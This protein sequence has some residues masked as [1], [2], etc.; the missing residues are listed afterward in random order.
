MKTAHIFTLVIAVGVIV[1][2]VV[3]LEAARPDDGAQFVSMWGKE[4]AGQGEFVGP[5]DIAVDQEGFVYVMD[6]YNFRIQKFTSEGRFLI[7]WGE[8]GK[9]NVVFSALNFLFPEDHEGQ[10]YYPARVAVGPDNLVYVADSYNNR[11]QVFTPEGTFV[12]K[13]GGMGLWGGRFRVTSGMAFDQRGHILVADF[14]NHRVQIFK[15]D[16][17]YLN[18]FGVQGQ[19]SGQFDGPIGLASS[20]AG[21][22]YVADFHNHRIQRFRR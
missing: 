11:V 2:A 19:E 22:L 3:T 13:W 10:F 15:T 16:G 12:R 17:T 6:E 18:R 1:A 9:V 14:Y 20:P 7:A 8:K 4:G 5:F 21:D